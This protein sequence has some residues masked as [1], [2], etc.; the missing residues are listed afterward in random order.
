MILDTSAWKIH[1]PEWV[2]KREKDWPVFKKWLT[3][4]YGSD[5]DRSLSGSLSN[6]KHFYDSGML[7]E[8]AEG[9]GSSVGYEAALALHPN[10]T[11]KAA[12]ELINFY[13]IYG[14][15][16]D[17][18]GYFRHYFLERLRYLD[19]INS[20][21]LSEDFMLALLEGAYG[22]SMDEAGKILGFDPKTKYLEVFKTLGEKLF[23]YFY[24]GESEAMT[25]DIATYMLPFYLDALS[26]M[27]DDEAHRCD[28][29]FRSDLKTKRIVYGTGVVTDAKQL[30]F[31]ESLLGGIQSRLDIM[32]PYT[33]E[34]MQRLLE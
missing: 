4:Y 19:L 20:G 13:F 27:T 11:V 30:S 32:A 15:R 7:D 22:H 26:M 24:S 21:V 31:M 18:K 12:H 8:K 34:N 23:G 9:Y 33:R 17:L 28:F 29:D 3:E 6:A 10:F 16:Y 25:Y 1:D 14:K 5:E 2:K